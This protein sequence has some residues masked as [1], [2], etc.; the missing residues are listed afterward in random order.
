MVQGN[1]Q[2]LGEGVPP[3]Q[4]SQMREP[5]S[6]SNISSSDSLDLISSGPSFLE[7]ILAGVRPSQPNLNTYTQV[8]L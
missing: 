2:T 7:R 3:A 5:I 1:A 4:K 8:A 6:Q